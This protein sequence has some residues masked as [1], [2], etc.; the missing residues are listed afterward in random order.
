MAK[1][2]SISFNLG[3]NWPLGK[4]SFL[5]IDCDVL[6]I[7][8]NFRYFVLAKNYKDKFYNSYKDIPLSIEE[9]KKII[10]QNSS[11]NYL[12][13][14]IFV[15]EVY[16]GTG[17]KNVIAGMKIDA[18]AKCPSHAIGDTMVDSSYYFEF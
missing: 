9:L 7:K 12:T 13:G 8:K 15:I 2:C 17:R 1:E 11:K 16:K 18:R 10:S 14:D 4:I 6:T 3:Y 5:G